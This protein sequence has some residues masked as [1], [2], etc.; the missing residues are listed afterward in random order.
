M[1][2]IFDEITYVYINI[3][4]LKKQTTP[5]FGTMLLLLEQ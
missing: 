4:V 2:I 3:T 5:D 1:F